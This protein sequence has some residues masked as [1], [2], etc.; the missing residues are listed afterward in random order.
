MKIE[1][2]REEDG[3]SP[4][5]H[6][7]V[8]RHEKGMIVVGKPSWSLAGGIVTGAIVDLVAFPLLCA[9]FVFG[10]YVLFV[11]VTRER[12]FLPLVMG[13]LLVAIPGGL[14][15]LFAGAQANLFPYECRFQKTDGGLWAVQRR[16][17]FLHF[18]WR[19]L[20]E[21]WTII[22]QPSY[23][24]GEWGYFFLIKGHRAKVPLTPPSVFTESK[25]QAKRAASEDLRVLEASFG[26][27]GEWRRWDS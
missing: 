8:L 23:S 26:V 1:I 16:F 9:M 24:R 19:E 10:V 11:A 22:C 17:W 21:D 27:Q 3:R 15:P 6:A 7:F 25:E 13:I 2:E 18:H 12:A 4:Q 5:S 20:G 14:F